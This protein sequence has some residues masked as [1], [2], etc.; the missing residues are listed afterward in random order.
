MSQRLRYL[1]ARHLAKN[2]TG[3]ER[4]ELMGLSLDPALQNDLKELIDEAWHETG[5]TEDITDEKAEDILEKI[6]GQK[7]APVIKL[8]NRK[9]WRIAAAVLLIAGLGSYLLL[10]NKK[11]LAPAEKTELAVH[12]VEAPKVTRA[13]IMLTD[14]RKITIDSL[15]NGILA[16]E[17]GISITK[18][19]KGEIIYSDNHTASNGSAYNTLINPRGSRLA[20]LTLIDGT[21]VWLNTE[22]SIRYYTTAGTER[23]VEITGEA[24]F[25]VAKD[26]AHRFTVLANGVTTTVTG[27]HFNVNSYK[28]ENKIS[29]TLLEGSVQ[30]EMNGNTNSLKPGQQAQAAGRI[31]IV[32]DADTEAVM[33]WKNGLFHFVNADL[34]T[35]MAQLA[36][37]Y[38]MDVQYENTVPVR[39]FEGKIQRDLSLSDVLEGLAKSEV[40]YRI[41]GRKLIIE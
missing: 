40:R 18:N 16:T 19:E 27:T 36:R 3:N 12:D 33:A 23:H 28:E 41:E 6:T 35:V 24:Y 30:V 22:S 7:T 2:I 25:E 32:D 17:S 37:W 10:S 34:A 26:H 5:E 13:M 14:G 11:N 4:R 8:H 39:R 20:S 9:W 21:K 31:T 1:F 15:S 29:V 38:D